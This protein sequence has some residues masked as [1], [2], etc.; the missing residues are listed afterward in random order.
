[1]LSE[2]FHTDEYRVLLVAEKY[3]TGFDE[4]LLHTMYVDKK[5]DGIKAVQTL[6]RLNRICKGKNDTFVLDFVNEP[7]A[8][9]Q[10]FQP[11]YEVTNLERITDPNI[12]Y[13][14]QRELDAY[15]IYTEEEIDGVCKLEFSNKKKTAKTQEKLNSILDR[16][17]RRYGQELNREEQDEFKG[18]AGKYIRTY[19]FILQ[20]GPFVDVS[21]HKLY[22][23]HNYLLR[24]LPKNGS[25]GVSLADDVALEYYR[26]DKVFEGRISLSPDEEG[27]LKPTSFGKGVGK[28]EEKEKLSE[29]IERLNDR[30]GTE[31]TDTD[32][33]SYDQIKEDI[34]NNEDLVQ[35][36][37][38]NTKDNF[39]FSYKR[40]FW[41]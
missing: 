37:Q 32:K 35:K 14:L 22:I 19:S 29:I 10:A 13:D 7:E 20:I 28:E 3:Q 38:T 24:K 41:M 12:L 8:I 18:A 15:Q 2:K 26:N 1:M 21:L 17:V 39:K 34:I 4:P 31:F 25:E 6:S 30:F 11:Y 23:F 40:L 16:S 33:L 27:E 9:Q 36:A 5:L